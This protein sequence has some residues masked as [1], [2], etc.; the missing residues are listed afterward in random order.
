M[1]VRILHPDPRIVPDMGARVTFLG[2][3]AGAGRAAPTRAKG[4]IVDPAAIRSGAG[5]PPV[6]FVIE[7]GKLEQRRLVL[8]EPANGG[9]IVLSGTPEELQ[10]N[11]DIVNAYLA[12]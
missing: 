3:S 9:R 8:G 6:A 1:R 2:P 7:G 5:A 11:D 4:L 12:F 10:S